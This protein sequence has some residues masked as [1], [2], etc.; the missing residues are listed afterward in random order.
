[1]SSGISQIGGN[2]MHS[3]QQ[4]VLLHDTRHCYELA[5]GQGWPTCYKPTHSNVCT[6]MKDCEETSTLKLEGLSGEHVAFLH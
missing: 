6:Y 5:R 4:S 3:R 2:F 1:M